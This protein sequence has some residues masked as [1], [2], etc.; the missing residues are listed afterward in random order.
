MK[1]I[2]MSLRYD[3]KPYT[4]CCGIEVV[5]AFDSSTLNSCISCWCD[6]SSERSGDFVFGMYKLRY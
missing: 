6:L 5:E 1:S 4:E 3:L 2:I